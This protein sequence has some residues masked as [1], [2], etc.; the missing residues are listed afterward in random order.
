M[1]LKAAENR[2]IKPPIFWRPLIVATRRCGGAWLWRN[3]IDSEN[4]LWSAALWQTVRHAITS[5]NSYP[6]RRG[7]WIVVWSQGTL[8]MGTSNGFTSHVMT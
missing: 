2:E 6:P 1:Q 8:Q 3:A 5:A 4:S 7:S